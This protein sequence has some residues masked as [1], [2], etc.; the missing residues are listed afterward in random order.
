MRIL[1][2]F[3]IRSRVNQFLNTLQLYDHF[4]HDWENV[5]VVV[6]FDKDDLSITGDFIDATKSMIRANV[7][8]YA[9]EPQGKIAA[10]N[11]DM[12]HYND[13]D[14]LVLASDDMIPQQPWW[15]VFLR[16]EMAEHFPDTDGVLFHNDGYIGR[17]LNTMCIMG[18][19]YYD[20]F[21]YIYH[22]DY[23]SLWCDNEFH[24]VAESA[25]K[26]IYFDSCLFKH[27]HYSRNS[28]VKMDALMK[29]NESFYRHDSLTFAKRKAQGFP[30]KSIFDK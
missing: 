29:H 1:L 27:E 5:Q 16:E 23:I 12:Q 20:R 18:R 11:R 22:P 17:K 28:A 30:L 6:S 25:G 24:E 26:M 8:F 21:G 4:C 3:P 19:K 2:K 15:D 13:W 14:I 9:G 7:D 10:V